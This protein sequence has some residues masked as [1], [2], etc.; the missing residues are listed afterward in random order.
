M[1]ERQ[2]YNATREIKSQTVEDIQKMLV[3][4]LKTMNK[5]ERE[6]FRIAASELL[7]PMH[8]EISPKFV[9]RAI[10]VDPNAEPSIPGFGTASLLAQLG[11]S[12]YLRTPV[13]IE[14]FVQDDYFL[15]ETCKTLYR[16]Y[17][18]DLKEIF[19]GDYNQIIFT[20]GLAVGKTFVSAIGCCY[21]IYMLSCLRDPLRTMGLAPGSDLHGVGL[22]A[23]E[24]LARDVVMRN[25]V[26]KIAPSPYF[27]KHFKPKVTQKE[28]RFPN[29]IKMVA[30]ASSDTSMLGLNILFALV[31]EADFFRQEKQGDG[32]VVS[33][34][35]VL[36]DGLLGRMVGRF[37]RN[38]KIFL[39]CSKTSRDSF[40]YKRIAD[41]EN[42]P[43]VFVRDYALWEAKPD[44]YPMDDTSFYVMC[45][46]EAILSKIVVNPV[47]IEQYRTVGAP[48]RCE[49]FEVPGDLRP[50]FEN[51]LERSIRDI[52]GVATASI[53]RYFQHVDKL[54]LIIDKERRAPFSVETYDPK[55][56]GEFLWHELVERKVVHTM[57]RS[58]S[59]WAP[60]V[61]P[62]IPRHAHI[63]AAV[64]GNAASICV[65]HRAGDIEMLRDVIGSKRKVVERVPLVWI[66]FILRIIPPTVGEIEQAQLRRLV[67]AL[68]QHGF[69]FSLVT[70]D[71]FQAADALQL[72]RGQ[73]INARKQ[74]VGWAQYQALKSAIYEGR[75]NVYPS[76]TL[77]AELRGLEV[78]WLKRVI[79]KP[80]F[81]GG[82]VG[83]KDMTDSL[84]GVVYTLTTGQTHVDVGIPAL[85]GS[86]GWDDGGDIHQHL[87]RLNSPSYIDWMVGTQ[88][89]AGDQAGR[90]VE[91]ELGIGGMMDSL[92][93]FLMSGD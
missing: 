61:N 92:P 41:A 78:D 70:Q 81:F 34:A 19:G 56:G 72:Y 10:R 27:Q 8:M 85:M 31:D 58:Q 45:G 49:F 60:R 76:V 25:I 30:R 54:P 91:I 38:G 51:N 57:G 53:T 20:G 75:V 22:S 23:A 9:L 35:Q 18:A 62:D 52:A 5:E 33:L 17:Y 77:E 68:E 46:N 89:R 50:L 1:I 48:E 12:H 59:I 84:A 86:S 63:D 11:S 6:T 43:R 4:D 90:E 37:K 65:G 80:A 24:Y 69:N 36:F 28:I 13:D 44:D 79:R 42:D 74:P 26:G 87:G 71:Q 82:E 55:Y 29:D 67:F 39:P 7:A 66:D 93:P 3:D 21:I 40:I 64:T 83:S 14:T 88:H 32:A 47:E 2:T 73:G 15:G 16:P